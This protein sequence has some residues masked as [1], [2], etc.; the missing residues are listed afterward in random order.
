MKV[1]KE[2]GS[3]DPS[4]QKVPAI[5]K[6]RNAGVNYSILTAIS[7][8]I[9]SLGT[10]TAIPSFSPDFKS[11]LEITFLNAGEYPLDVRHSFKTLSIQFHFQFGKQSE[12]TGAKL[13]K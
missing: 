9:V 2:N 6:N 7:F 10:Y 8:K 11:A 4:Y 1:Y 3:T 5:S 13:G 12:I